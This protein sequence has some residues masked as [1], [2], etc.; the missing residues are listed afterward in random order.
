MDSFSLIVKAVEASRERHGIAG[1]VLVGLSGGA[2]SVALLRALCALGQPSRLMLHAAYVHHGLRPEAEEEADFCRALCDQL[3]VP[4]AVLRVQVPDSGS[5]EAAAREARYAA[6]TAEMRRT[7]CTVLALAH[8]QDDQAETLLLHL[9]HGAGTAGMGGMAEYRAPL[10]R[11]LL[12]LRRETLRAALTELGQPWRE[13]ASNADTAYARNYLRHC[14]LPQIEQA[15]PSAVSALSR[16]AELLRAENE[17]WITRAD[18]WLRQ[19]GSGGPWHF[20][21]AEPLQMASVAFQRHILRRYAQRLGMELA[22]SHVEALRDLLRQPPGSACN[23]PGDAHAL[24]TRERLH[25]L[26]PDRQSAVWPRTL[27]RV[28]P[29]ESQ[30]G[31][32]KRTQ[33]FPAEIWERAVLR[34]R[35]QGDRIVPFG[36]KGRRRLKDFFLDHGIDE[37][38]RQDWPLLCDGSDV[39]W[40]VGVGASERA[41][42][43][44]G[45]AGVFVT[46]TGDLP[47]QILPWDEEEKHHAA[48]QT[49]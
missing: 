20:V 40:V 9:L 32:G 2:D 10:W 14:V 35:E 11:P 17:D 4:F 24:R 16:S 28:E 37:P 6:L 26:T 25:F 42:L 36:M 43:R 47:D 23:L 33:A 31:D 44:P 8:H 46:F 29:F 34:T 45:Q 13:D 41:R 30:T 1:G 3:G 19:Y 27:F 39:L 49:V 22:F 5:L 21:L 15:F 12:S 38:F 18:T 48:V 7:D